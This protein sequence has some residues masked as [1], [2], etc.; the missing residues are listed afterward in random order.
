MLSRDMGWD[1]SFWNLASASNFR[2]IIL[3]SNLAVSWDL[4]VRSL[5]ASEYKVRWPCWKWRHSNGNVDI[6]TK[7][8]SL[9]EPK[10]V[11]M[12]TSG[13]ASDETSKWHFRFIGWKLRGLSV[14]PDTK[15]RYY[16]WNLKA[17][18]ELGH[19]S[20][21]LARCVQV[22][23]FPSELRLLPLG[24][25]FKFWRK[26]KKIYLKTRYLKKIS[27]EYLPFC[28]GLNVLS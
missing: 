5:T 9:A 23:F 13:T 14:F 8:S 24:T 18:T 1:G 7:F 12:T 28:P 17:M 2:A 26:K 3:T 22:C 20:L 4:M 19:W 25:H 15:Y 6:L 27:A 10:V 16:I 11:N 21:P